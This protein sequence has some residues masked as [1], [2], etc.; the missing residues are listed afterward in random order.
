M[1]TKA[2]AI[3]NTANTEP[4]RDVT[5]AQAETLKC[6]FYPIGLSMEELSRKFSKIK[7]KKSYDYC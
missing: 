4:K 3:T 2:Q 7:S 1:K 5:K 6:G